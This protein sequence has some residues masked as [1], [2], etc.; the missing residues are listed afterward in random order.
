MDTALGKESIL[1]DITLVFRTLWQ[2][3]MFPVTFAKETDRQSG[4][5]ADRQAGRQAGTQTG[6]QAHR[7]TDTSI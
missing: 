3:D 2:T 1:D 4:R 5:Q 7:Q 6:R